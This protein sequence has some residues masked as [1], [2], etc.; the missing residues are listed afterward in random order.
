[1]SPASLKYRISLTNSMKS[2]DKIIKECID[3]V[4]NEAYGHQDLLYDF[5]KDAGFGDNNMSWDFIEKCK[6]R[7]GEPIGKGLDRIVFQ[8]DDYRILKVA[9]GNGASVKQNIAE[10][11]FYEYYKNIRQWLCI[12]PMIYDHAKDYQWIVMEYVLPFTLEDLSHFGVPFGVFKDAIRYLLIKSGEYTYKE[13]RSKRR[14]PEMGGYQDDN[15][16]PEESALN[17]YKSAYG[18]CC[19]KLS[20][21]KPIFAVLS[22]PNNLK[23]NISELFRIV[24][25]G[26]RN[27]T[28]PN[29]GLG[30]DLNGEGR[31]V[32]LDTGLYGWK[33]GKCKW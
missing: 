29:L 12:T 33:D 3:K 4:V 14:N 15:D 8:I 1:M 23:I 24:D 28:L 10:C 7:Y 19:S 27:R 6:K 2:I 9:Y 22:R 26:N 17:R 32:L 21:F 11:K 18:F 13:M 20:N 16:D 31:L 5:E 25:K 30:Y